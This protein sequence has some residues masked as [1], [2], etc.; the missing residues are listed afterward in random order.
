MYL[1]LSA[2]KDPRSVAETFCNVA[3]TNKFDCE[4]DVAK[5]FCN[6]PILLAPL[7]TPT[8]KT[9]TISRMRYSY[10]FSRLGTT[11]RQQKGQKRRT[12][13]FCRMDSIFDR[14]VSMPDGRLLPNS[15]ILGNGVEG[16]AVVV[17]H[18]AVSR[19]TLVL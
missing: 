11:Y 9:L 3:I 4:C 1:T 14:R 6:G 19:G 17:D 8:I 7:D 10:R 5:Y 16:D 2:G 13:S 15:S 12:K 18:V